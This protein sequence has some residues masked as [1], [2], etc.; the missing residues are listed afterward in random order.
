M[1]YELL[2]AARRDIKAIFRLNKELI[3]RYEDVARINYSKV[4]KLVQSGVKER[5][6]EYERIT[7][8]GETAGYLLVTEKPDC[9]ELE[10][11]FLYP[12]FQNRGIGTA[13]VRSVIEH[14]NKP[15]TLYV[16]IKNTGALNLYE[17]LGFQISETVHE[18][19]YKMIYRR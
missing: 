1:N 11:L 18:T 3:D 13:I 19:R 12:K 5:I 14:T 16:F 10:D 4:M 2:P 7:C 17:R 15:V 8:G 6:G 9:L